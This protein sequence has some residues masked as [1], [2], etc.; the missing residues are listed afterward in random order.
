[1][2]ASGVFYTVSVVVASAS[3]HGRR[4]AEDC[5]H[6]VVGKVIRIHSR[7]VETLIDGRLE[8]G[9]WYREQAGNI[10]GVLNAYA[11]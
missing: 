2:E 4:V 7:G 11:A 3:C 9:W 8:M 5:A 6:L 10:I 1:M